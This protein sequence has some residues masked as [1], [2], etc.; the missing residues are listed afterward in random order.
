MKIKN[1]IIQNT[2]G[3][4]AAVIFPCNLQSQTSHIRGNLYNNISKKLLFENNL[5]NKNVLQHLCELRFKLIKI[6]WP[7]L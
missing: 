6:L 2:Q 5:L 4:R 7:A 1:I 3:T